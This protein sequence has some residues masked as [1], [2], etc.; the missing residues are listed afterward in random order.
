MNH[1][2]LLSIVRLK[3]AD[4]YQLGPDSLVQAGVP[5]GKEERLTLPTSRIFPG[6]DH[7]CR[8]YVP[9]KYDAA[10]PAAPRL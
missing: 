7:D 10:K 5:Q 2:L 3:A 1:K 4:D 8:V 9:A 6:A